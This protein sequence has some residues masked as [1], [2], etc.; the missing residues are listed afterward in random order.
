MQLLTDGLILRTP[1]YDKRWLLVYPGLLRVSPL[2][3]KAGLTHHL[4]LGSLQLGDKRGPNFTE[5]VMFD[6]LSSR[7]FPE[8]NALVLETSVDSA[9]VVENDTSTC[10]FVRGR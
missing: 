5:G 3:S 6:F 7:T 10:E 2:K 8:I 4:E 1:S 9:L